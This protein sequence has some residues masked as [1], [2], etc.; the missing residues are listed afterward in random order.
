MAALLSVLV[1]LDTLFITREQ[2]ARHAEIAAST[3]S[4]LELIATFITEPLL[5][6][7]FTVVEQFLVQW[8]KKQA[9][10]TSLR[11]ISPAGFPI[12]EFHRPRP[13]APPLRMT[14]TVTF[15]GQHLL[16]L[17]ISKDLTPLTRHI[18][19]FK[20]QLIRRSLVVTLGMGLLL[21]TILRLLAIR[22]LEK[23]I[24]RRHQAERNLQEAHDL[25][26]RR[27][28]ERTTELLGVVE[29]LHD[30]ITER[31]LIEQ[32]LSESE[33]RYREIY[34]APSEAIF[35]HDDKTGVILDVNRAM[36]EMYGYA[37]DEALQLDLAALS[38]AEPLYTQDEAARHLANAKTKG[39]QLFPWRARKKDGT[40]FWVEVALKHTEIMDKSYIVA[41]VRNIDARKQA[42]D[43]LAEERER[44]AVT[45]RSIGDGVITTDTAGNVVLV[46]KEAERLTGWQQQEAAGQPIAEIFAIFDPKTRT[47][48]DNPVDRILASGKITDL[49]GTPIL[50]ARDGTERFIADS[51]APIRDQ[52]SRVIGAVLV[53]RDTTE[54]LHM[55]RELLK[56]KKLESVGLLAGGIAHDFN[57]ILMAILGNINLAGQFLPPDHKAAALLTQVEKATHRAKGLTQQLLTF[58]KGGEPVKET[59]SIRDVIIDSA[60]FV[61]H[62]T[63]IA[64]HYHMAEDLW[65]VDIDRG[66]MSQ[67]IQNLILNAVHA[68]P[69]GGVINIHGENVASIAGQ[70]ILLPHEK[71]Y[72]KITISDTGTGIPAEIIENIFDPYFSTREGGSGLGLATTYSII[73]K[74]DGHI[75]AQS[76]PG[77]GAT[78]TILLPAA[79]NTLLHAAEETPPA[80]TQSG[81]GRILVMDDEEMLRIFCQNVL[82][83][84]GFEVVLAKDGAEAV[85]LYRQALE[86]DEKKIDLTI[87][88]LT[89]PGGMGGR[90]AV[91]EILALN[92]AA[93][94]IVSSGYSN[95]PILANYREFGFHAALVKP[96]E[97][98]EL[99]KAIN[100]LL[101]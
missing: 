30:E 69:D 16:D 34:N 29:K 88:D 5:R 1:L 56:A 94:V 18:E 15:N 84:L 91:Q 87:M 41:V 25:L 48:S 100:T 9:D 72:V 79:T 62:G 46:N 45:L 52:Q 55:E 6:H 80:V 7:D 19:N 10:V 49:D 93:K 23:E 20:Q 44:L 14:W 65:L 92:P 17:E 86:R 38:S 101:S 68:M 73:S 43:L 81:Q 59:A 51:G 2:D 22:P 70:E 63:K 83:Y 82:T 35:I 58:A 67:V 64:C 47:P 66:Q 11:A 28:K 96:Y 39:P 85:A 32:N 71:R 98:Q 36:L 21:W 95:D 33:E 54:Q 27:V 26:E 57:N 40:L 37:Y 8:G 75:S 3:Q 90:E 60:D 99:T 31:E 4:E 12:C 97:I 50:V 61:L 77:E 53:F 74:H 89:I 13:P 76:P 42:E 24:A 78:F